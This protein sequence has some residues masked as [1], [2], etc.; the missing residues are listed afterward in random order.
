MP[1]EKLLFPLGCMPAWEQLELRSELV[2]ELV[3]EL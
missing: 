2:L 3:S 1:L